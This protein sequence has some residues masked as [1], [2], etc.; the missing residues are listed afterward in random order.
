MGDVG[1]CCKSIVEAHG[2]R[3]GYA[4]AL[5]G[6]ATFTFTLLQAPAGTEGE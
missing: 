2:G 5:N 1:S 3:I 6:G 4:P